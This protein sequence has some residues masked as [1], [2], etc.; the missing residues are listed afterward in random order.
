MW[1]LIISFFPLKCH[2]AYI[3]LL[4]LTEKAIFELVDNTVSTKDIRILY[5][6]GQE[7]TSENSEDLDIAKVFTYISRMLG[8][9]YFSC[10]T[11]IVSFVRFYKNKT[12]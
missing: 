5:R 3:F 8:K 9:L 6:I 10:K 7:D 12:G 4:I 1:E 11:I 2:H